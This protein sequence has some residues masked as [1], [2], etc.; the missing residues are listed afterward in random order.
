M[1][2]NFP[3]RLCKRLLFIFLGT[4]LFAIGA[5]AQVKITGKVTGKDGNGLPGISVLLRNTNNGICY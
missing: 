3:A 5:L 1:R 2:K 4:N